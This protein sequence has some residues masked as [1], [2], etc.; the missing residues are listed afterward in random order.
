MTEITNEIS[1]QAAINYAA[2]RD[3]PRLTM[4]YGV[5]PNC[6]K[7]LAEYDALLAWLVDHPAYQQVH[8]A[9]TGPVQPYIDTMYQ[10]MR[11]AIIG[12]MQAIEAGAPGTFPGVVVPE[13][14]PE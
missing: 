7:A 3:A 12:V 6:V 14:E 9:T 10:A 5:Y 11:Q 13:S 2:Y 1:L 8:D 4:A